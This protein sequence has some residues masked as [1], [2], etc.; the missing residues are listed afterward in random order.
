M[1]RFLNFF[2]AGPD[3]EEEPRLSIRDSLS[4]NSDSDV[5]TTPHV[6]LPGERRTGRRLLVDGEIVHETTSDTDITKPTG[7]RK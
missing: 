4:R 5:R 3:D 6:V 1:P 7:M 2:S